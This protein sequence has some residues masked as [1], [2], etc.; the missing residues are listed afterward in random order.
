MKNQQEKLQKK[1]Q[2][3]LKDNDRLLAKYKLEARLVVNFAT[4]RKVPL[5][6]KIALWIVNKQGG[7]LDMQFE[8][9][10]K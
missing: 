1:A 9:K 8:Y 4:K 10:D 3:F 5:L 2:E 6:S 7:R